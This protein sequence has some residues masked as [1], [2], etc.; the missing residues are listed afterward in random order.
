VDY[1]ESGGV[2]LTEIPVMTLTIPGKQQN[3]TL[4]DAVVSAGQSGFGGFTDVYRTPGH[5]SL[6]HADPYPRARRWDPLT[7]ACDRVS[8]DRPVLGVLP[9]MTTP[10]R[11]GTPM[12]VGFAFAV[13]GTGV[14]AVAEGRE[15]A[16]AR[17]PGALILDTGGPLD[18]GVSVA[19][20]W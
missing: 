2:Y 20:S 16:K 5:V 18:V 8:S 17:P 4:V 11:K 7:L 3:K 15:W 19:L 9:L 6:R 1:P 14:M 12:E 10:S 13:S